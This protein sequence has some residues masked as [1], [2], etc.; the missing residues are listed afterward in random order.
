MFH[1]VRLSGSWVKTRCVD[2]TFVGTEFLPNP[3][4]MERV[5]AHAP[6]PVA[7][8]D[9]RS[10]P[11]TTTTT[12][13]V[14]APVRQT[15]PPTS[16]LSKALVAQDASV[17]DSQDEH[18]EDEM[19]VDQRAKLKRN[20]D[21]S[22]V[23]YYRVPRHLLPMLHGEDGE[24]MERFQHYTGT[25]IVLPSHASIGGEQTQRIPDHANLSIYGCG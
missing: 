21:L 2:F 22:E 20:I 10:M 18:D 13:T 5:L 23:T 14:A 9:S 17:Y 8:G 12:T 6:Q 4:A 7:V 24:T 3:R 11:A 15:R 19:L 25:Y 16:S 1:G